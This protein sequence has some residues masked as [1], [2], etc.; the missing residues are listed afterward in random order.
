MKLIKL[1]ISL[2]TVL[3]TFVE[4]ALAKADPEKAAYRQ[5]RE[6]TK[7]YQDVIYA[8]LK[9]RKSGCTKEKL[10]HRQEW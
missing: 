10:I 2:T 9:H 8:E 5:I 6:W 4:A 7:K 1:L 3:G